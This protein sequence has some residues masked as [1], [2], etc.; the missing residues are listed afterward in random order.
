MQDISK[1]IITRASKGDME[2]FKVMYD[3]ASG[4]VYSLAFRMTSNKE[5]AEEVTQDVFVKVYKNLRYFQFRSSFKTWVYR[6]V[7]NTA[8][9]FTKKRARTQNR[10]VEYDDAVKKDHA[11]HEPATELEKEMNKEYVMSLLSVLNPDQ[12]ACVVLR[13][14]EGLSYEEIANALKIN[15]NTVRSR[16]KRARGVLLAHFGKRGDKK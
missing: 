6:V 5:D 13:N 4:F 11:A 12:R 9:N 1:D 15:I 3:T 16:L 14:I 7:C 8:I 2:A 10:M